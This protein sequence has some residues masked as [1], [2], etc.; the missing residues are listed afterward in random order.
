MTSDHAQPA[1]AQY[2]ARPEVFIPTVN[3]GVIIPASSARSRFADDWER[4]RKKDPE[5]ECGQQSTLTS[6]VHGLHSAPDRHRHHRH[7]PTPSR[8][9]RA[10]IA[11]RL[12]LKRCAHVSMFIHTI[13]CLAFSFLHCGVRERWMDRWWCA[14]AVRTLSTCHCELSRAHTL[15]E[16]KGFPAPI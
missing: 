13:I 5:E 11:N 2:C 4:E 9:H 12:A 7:R 15:I 3:P 14:C 10:C 6:E 16:V 8:Q 1:T